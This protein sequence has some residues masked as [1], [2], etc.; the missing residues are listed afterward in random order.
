[1]LYSPVVKEGIESFLHKD[2]YTTASIDTLF[3]RNSILYHMSYVDKPRIRHW[4]LTWRLA[5]GLEIQF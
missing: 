4:I 5:D 2:T 1:M 3:A